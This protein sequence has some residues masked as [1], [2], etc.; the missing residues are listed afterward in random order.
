MATGTKMGMPQRASGRTAILVWSLTGV[1]LAINVLITWRELA[2]GDPEP[3]QSAWSLTGW[4]FVAAAFAISGA[5]IVSRSAGNVIGWLLLIPG[6]APV[7]GL[8]QLWLIGL[9]PPPQTVNL[10]VWL[11]IWITGVSWVFLIFPVFHLMLTF[12]T[13]RLQSPRWRWVA[14]LEIGML[15]AFLTLVALSETME[16]YEG[17]EVLWSVPNPIG[18]IGQAFWEEAFN[19]VWSTLLAILALSCLA[20]VIQRFRKGSPLERQQMKWLLLAVS[21][22]GLTYAVLAFQA[23]DGPQG[24]ADALFSISL[25]S[26]PIA[27]AVAVLRYRL[28]D[29]DRLVSR[30][31]SYAVVVGLLALLFFGMVSLLTSLLDAQSDVVVAGTTLAVAATFNPL[32][33]R[34]QNGVDRRFNRSRYDSQRV[35]DRF[36]GSLRDRIDPDEVVGGWLEVVTETMQPAAAGVWVRSR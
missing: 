34:V 14:G 22:F 18:F 6:L 26:I 5:L 7:V 25:T 12:P 20:A 1:T 2:G 11:A 28:Y 19:P 31:V 36:A 33:K 13:G 23:G 3:G 24:I 35:V 4:S 15:L 9:D 21:F 27:I 17:D 8:A 32:R 29:L 30:T 16:M 10:M